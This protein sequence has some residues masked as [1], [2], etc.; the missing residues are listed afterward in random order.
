MPS[1][2]ESNTMHLHTTRRT[3]LRE[4]LCLLLA[5]VVMTCM[6]SPGAQAPPVRWP[7]VLRQP[8][9]WYGQPEARAIADS[10]RKYQRDSGGWPKNIDMAGPP[11]P[12]PAGARPDSTIDNGATVT[13]IRFLARVFDAARDAGDRGRDR[14]RP[15]FPACR[16]VP[17]R[18]MAPVLPAAR[19]LLAPH[20]VQ[21]RGDG[22]RDDAARRLAS[23]R[24]RLA[25]VDG[26]RRTKAAAAVAR[27]TD[28]VLRAQVR[29][30]GKLTAWCA[31]HDEVTLEPR[32][33]RTY[34]HPSLRVGNGRDRPVPDGA[35]RDRPAHRGG[36]RRRGRLARAV[37]LQG[38]P[39]DRRADA[40]LRAG[41]TSRS[42]A[43][44]R[45]R[46][47]GRGSTRSG[48]TGRSS[49]AA[50]G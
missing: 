34:E 17:E 18:R 23:G 4:V 36:G 24:A 40:A 49:P 10:V 33:A 43:M 37:Q 50:T 32:K 27:G 30:G 8:D 15:R 9:A 42:C 31:Q 28:L 47:S 19:R 14:A 48:R 2:F 46:R 12:A 1:E 35:K 38:W 39:L 6:A 41:P 16:P 7:D 26:E 20:H 25:F 44:T 13:Q 22:R 29:V 3:A 21:R 11:E 45:R 5:C